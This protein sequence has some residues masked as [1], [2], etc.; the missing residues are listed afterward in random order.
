[1]VQDS[2]KFCSCEVNRTGYGL[3]HASAEWALAEL[4]K[5]EVPLLCDL[6]ELVHIVELVVDDEW[7]DWVDGARRGRFLMSL[8]KKSVL[9]SVHEAKNCR[10]RPRI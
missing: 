9:K 5:I 4:S 2:S 6:R 7:R 10:R 3:A 1:L 8:W